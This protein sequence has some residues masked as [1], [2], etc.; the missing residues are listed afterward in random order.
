MGDKDGV[1][2]EERE[3]PEEVQHHQQVHE[4]QKHKI[5]DPE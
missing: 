3:V 5:V 4:G 2:G 1:A